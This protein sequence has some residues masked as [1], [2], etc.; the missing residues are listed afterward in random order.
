MTAAESTI[1]TLVLTIIIIQA[2]LSIIII[3]ITICGTRLIEA[4]ALIIC[5][6][7]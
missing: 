7:C 3:I 4:V 6:G 5:A 2:H 1:P